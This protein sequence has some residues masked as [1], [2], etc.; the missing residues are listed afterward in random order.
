M[1]PVALLTLGLMIAGMFFTAKQVIT[2]A[3]FQSP[4]EFTTRINHLPNSESYECWWTVW[5]K[6]KA[7]ANPKQ[8]YVRNREVYVEKWHTTQK[9]FRIASGDKQTIKIGVFYYPH[10]QATINNKRIKLDKDES[11]TIL[12]SIPEA[13][14]EINLVFVEPQIIK[15][16]SILSI[17]V[18][19]I[20]AG[21]VMFYFLKHSREIKI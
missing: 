10:W 11:G 13:D 8:I 7:F 16:A 20:F 14:S 5:A 3:I 4:E 19:L 12:L 17:L 2:P 18:W 6:R 1:R 9:R 15:A 21:L